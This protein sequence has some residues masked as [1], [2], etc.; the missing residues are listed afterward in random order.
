[1]AA[2]AD[3]DETSSD[4]VKIEASGGADWAWLGQI[5]SSDSH[6]PNIKTGLTKSELRDLMGHERIA[7]G[8]GHT[9]AGEHR[10]DSANPIDLVVER[11]GSGLGPNG[12]ASI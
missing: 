4:P 3:V 5:M 8:R 6:E 1:M 12:Y 2:F 9:H 7:V 10:I 11:R